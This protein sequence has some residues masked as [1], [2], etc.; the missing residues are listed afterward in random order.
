MQRS[1]Q[2]S[3]C[4]PR[5]GGWTFFKYV[6]PK[7]KKIKLKI[8]KLGV[9]GWL[10]QLSVRLLVGHVSSGHDLTVCG[11][12]PLH[13]QCGACMRFALF[14]SSAPPL[15]VPPPQINKN[16]SFA[17]DFP[18]RFSSWLTT[19]NSALVRRG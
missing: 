16:L 17:V 18:Y 8:Q 9:P 2:I 7:K 19:M 6:M 4:R 12:E 13:W 1:N 10:S 15:L 5:K 3:L 14:L 11:L